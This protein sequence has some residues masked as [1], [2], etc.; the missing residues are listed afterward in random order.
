[1]QT[2]QHKRNQQEETTPTDQGSSPV[3]DR[4]PELLSGGVD[5]VSIE[6]I[7]SLLDRFGGSFADRAFTSDEIVYCS[8]KA[9]PSQHYAARWAAK[10]AAI[11]ALPEVD[12]PVTVCGVEVVRACGQP[13][14]RWRSPAAKAA[15]SRL[16]ERHGIANGS[17][18]THLS[19]SHDLTVGCSIAQVLIGARGDFR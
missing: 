19:M 13:L 6:R 11:K 12:P 7:E 5:V 1:M 15:A 14:L 9:Q 16:A 17:L 3:C 8:S 4:P 18:Q 10:E 2:D